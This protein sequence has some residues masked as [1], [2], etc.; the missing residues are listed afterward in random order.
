MICID[1]Q[2][3]KIILLLRVNVIIFLESFICPK[4]VDYFSP[5][6]TSVSLVFTL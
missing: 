1:T 6:L 4:T 3:D 5:F 2:G